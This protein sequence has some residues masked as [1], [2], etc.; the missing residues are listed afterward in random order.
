[1]KGCETTNIKALDIRAVAGR[2][3]CNMERQPGSSIHY[4]TAVMVATRRAYMLESGITFTA[5]A[6]H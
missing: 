6:D 3:C 5:A 2:G 1:M 4:S